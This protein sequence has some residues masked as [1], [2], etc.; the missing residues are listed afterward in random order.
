M[1][2]SRARVPA[3]TLPTAIAATAAL[4]LGGS[5]IADRGPDPL[6]TERAAQTQ[7]RTL[8][9]SEGKTTFA[10]PQNFTRR[11]KKRDKL[12]YGQVAFSNPAGQQSSGGVRCPNGTQVAG[13]GVL[14]ES[15]APGRQAI[16]A[17]LPFD[18]KDKN[19]DNDDG[20]IGVV[21]NLIGEDRQ[22]GVYVICR[23]TK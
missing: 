23:S 18:G 2:L 7:T 16:S 14:A 9:T 19:S 8:S 5:A 4:A 11:G 13:G 12:I 3:W 20:W 22:F 21:D 6:E 17:T 1:N 10:T 15:R